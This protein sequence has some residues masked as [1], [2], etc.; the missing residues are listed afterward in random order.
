MHHT[1]FVHIFA[2]F[3]TT[4]MWKCLISRFMEN[5]NKQRR[6]F[7]SVSELFL[8]S[9]GI[10]LQKGCLRHV[11]FSFRSKPSWTRLW[12]DDVDIRFTEKKARFANWP[13]ETFRSKNGFSS[14]SKIRFQSCN[15]LDKRLRFS[16]RNWSYSPFIKYFTQHRHC[17]L[18]GG[19]KN[20]LKAK[21]KRTLD[22]SLN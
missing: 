18:A 17:M 7:V 14:C 1:F 16:K 8:L 10:Q 3:C 11:S 9:L 13:T 5:L 4:T 12:F 20:K 6:N 15:V 21:S 2:V 19:K 22:R